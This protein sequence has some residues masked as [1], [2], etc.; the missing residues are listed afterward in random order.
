MNYWLIF[1]TVSL[2]TAGVSFAVITGIVVV[3]GY[4]DLRLMFRRLAEQR[5]HDHE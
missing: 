3:K 2:V 4:R 5:T 1:W